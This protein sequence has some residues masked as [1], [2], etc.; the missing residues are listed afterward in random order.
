MISIVNSLCN[1][2]CTTQSG[3]QL[4]MSPLQ[5]PVEPDED[6]QSKMLHPV[7]QMRIADAFDGLTEKQK[8]YAHHMSR[9]DWFSVLHQ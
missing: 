7:H 8:L 2:T 1:L 5:Y 3:Q 6:G 4:R 9:C